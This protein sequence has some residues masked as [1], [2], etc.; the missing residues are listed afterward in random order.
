M[1]QLATSHLE[2]NLAALARGSPDAVARIRSAATRPDFELLETRDGVPTAQ[3]G[4]GAHARLLAS[5]YRPL[6]EAEKLVAPIDIKHAAVFVVAGFGMGYHIAALARK[7]GRTGIIIVFEPDAALLRSTLESVDCAEWIERSNVCVLCDPDDGA[8]MGE[9]LRGLEGLVGLGVSLVQHPASGPRLGASAKRFHERFRGVVDAVSMTVTTTLFQSRVTIRN[10]LQNA[11]VYASGRGVAELAGA[12]AGRPAI[13]VSAGPSLQRNVNL[14]LEPGVRERCVIIA[15]QTVLHPLLA[16]GIRPHFVTALDYSEINKRF[17]EGLTAAQV[18]GITLVVEPK[19]NPSVLMAWPGKVLCAG[20]TTLDLVLGEELAGDHGKLKQGA[21]VAHL[22][23]YLA[24]HLGCDPVALIGQDLGFTD[25]QY[26]AAGASIHSIWAGE[27]NEFKSLELLEWQRIVRMGPHLRPTTDDL[28]RPVYTDTQM[29]AY[30]TQFET[31]FREDALRGLTTIDATEG[32]V[33]KQHASTRALRWFLDGHARQDGPAIQELLASC[34]RAGPGD[35]PARR[36]RREKGLRPRIR[37]VRGQVARVEDLSRQT[38]RLLS[39]M[40]DHREDQRRVNRLIEKVHAHA[41]E[42]ETL[43]PGFALTQLLGQK[44]VFNRVRSDRLIHLRD[45]SDEHERQALQIDRD[46]DNVQGL[47]LAAAD[48]RVMLDGCLSVL[49]GGE[50]ITRDLPKSERELSRERT[51]RG[52]RPVMFGVA[53]APVRSSVVSAVVPVDPHRGGLG[54]ARRLDVPFAGRCSVLA[55]TVDRLLAC[56]ELRDVTLVGEDA[57]AISAL[58]EPR[59]LSAGRVRVL[60][61]ENRTDE[62]RERAI[63]VGRLWARACWRGGLGDLSVFDECFDPG[64]CAIALERAGADA[65]LVAGPDWVAVD[66]ALCA[67]IIR[68]HNENPVHHRLSFTQAAPGLCGCIVTRDL[69]SDL[70]ESVRPSRTVFATIGGVLSYMPAAPLQDLIAHPICIGLSGVVRDCGLRLIADTPL[71]R[72]AL[73]AVLASGELSAAQIAVA[74]ADRML[75]AAPDELIEELIIARS[76][77]DVASLVRR[78]AA[79]RPDRVVTFGGPHWDPIA[80]APELADWIADV[81]AAGIA[82]VH[83]RTRLKDANIADIRGILDRGV[84]ILSADLPT[85]TD[86][87][88]TRCAIEQLAATRQELVG[89][90]G[91]GVPWIVPRLTRCDSSY[92]LV[93]QFVSAAV[94]SCG[95]GALDPLGAPRPGERIAPLPPPGI[96][97]ARFARTRRT[98]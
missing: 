84:D 96:A 21:T 44:I 97:A 79:D 26:Y 37:D 54:F 80:A 43:R 89:D 23:Y 67:Q 31:D 10:L 68:R 60:T 1:T 62:R 45:S 58:L 16:K 40:R 92:G 19:V 94:M 76:G 34:H 74:V 32:G 48:L 47:E 41:A 13:V 50:R 2:A 12:C 6:D 65:A 5:K 17:Y 27:L 33:R 70:A 22:A 42:V 49:D 72:E 3:L 95:W 9:A 51:E 30:L 14:L 78:F 88:R 91:M 4:Q 46:I 52:A 75:S 63:A 15:A 56:P 93:E 82:A 98:A 85:D 61:N 57:S 20:D 64:A 69:C 83:V 29:H 25:G 81:K 18:E 38:V 77:L 86:A 8:A 87:P 90:G 73:A 53:P 36:A 71:M 55:A 28:G 35:D 59:Q 7:L 11:G 66:P 39:E 24:R